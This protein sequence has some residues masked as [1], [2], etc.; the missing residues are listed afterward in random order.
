M[1]GAA[2]RARTGGFRRSAASERD[3]VVGRGEE[4]GS[5]RNEIAVV[6]SAQSPINCREV[7]SLDEEH[8]ERPHND[9]R[10]PNNKSLAGIGRDAIHVRPRVVCAWRRS[11]RRVRHTECR[12]WPEQNARDYGEWAPRKKDRPV[13]L[14]LDSQVDGLEE[15]TRALQHTAREGEPAASA[16][17]MRLSIKICEEAWSRRANGGS[18][19]ISRSR[20]LARAS[21]SVECRRNES[22]PPSTEKNEIDV[23][24]LAQAVTPRHPDPP[25]RKERYGL[26]VGAIP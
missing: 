23:H 26:E 25:N 14:N 19:S 13:A 2:E 21:R 1:C 10:S 15:A 17:T 20:G 6:P 9:G 16:A 3:A 8:A 22:T 5:V 11:A 4:A 7:R 18:Y 12:Y 24:M